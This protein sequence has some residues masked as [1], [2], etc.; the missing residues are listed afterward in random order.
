MFPYQKTATMTITVAITVNLNSFFSLVLETGFGT[1]A[2]EAEL[3]I[4]KSKVGGPLLTWNIGV[5][6]V[7]HA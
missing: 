4:P 2:K 1:M 3:R 5:V 7:F 6:L